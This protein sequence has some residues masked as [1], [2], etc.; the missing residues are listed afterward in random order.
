[1]QQFGCYWGTS[2]HCSD[3]VD[4]SLLTDAVEKVDLSAGV[5]VLGVLLRLRFAGCRILLPPARR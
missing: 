1:M 4:L 2:G 5:L 3:I